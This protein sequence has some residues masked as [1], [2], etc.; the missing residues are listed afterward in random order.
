MAAEILDIQSYEPRSS[1][2]FFFDNNI[3]MFLYCPIS[4]YYKS[5]Q[6]IYSKFLQKV[7]SAGAGIFINS[8]ILSEFANANFRLDFDLWKKEESKFE[9]SYK[10]DFVGSFRYKETAEEIKSSIH[11]ILKLCEKSSDDFNAVDFPRVLNHLNSID[12][13]DSYYLELAS[14]KNW[15]I[16]TDDRDFVNYKNHDCTVITSH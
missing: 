15:K 2:I 16:V 3:W 8:L 14:L 5:K 7:T 11:Q 13:N 10:K 6:Q 4:G 9:A 1:D 12:F